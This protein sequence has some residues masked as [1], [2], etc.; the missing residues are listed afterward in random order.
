MK[1]F[2]SFIAVCKKEWIELKRY[3]FNTVVGLCMFLLMFMALFSGAKSI[4]QNNFSLMDSLEGFLIGYALW[5]LAM[6]AFADTA[7]AIIDE[8]RKGTLEQLYMTDVPFTWLLI[9]KNMI[10]TIIYS[11]IFVVIILIQTKVTGITLNLDFISVFITLFIG[12]FSL[13]GIG[14]ILAGLG[15]IFKK[16]QNLLGV[17]QF[18]LVGIMIVSP[19][20]LPFVRLL[21]FVEGRE[22][23]MDIMRNG[24]SLWD[25][26]IYNWLFLLA[27]SIF[28]LVVGIYGYKIA[29]MQVLKRGMLGQY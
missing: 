12:L 22:M 25:F 16:I 17:T 20:S 18:I 7:H 11:I 9:S 24:Y 28:Y 27:N 23:I 1:Y 19:T 13:Y 3:W 6:G 2:N 26:S 10:S 29:E 8:S 4:G 15:L 5:F 21:P 14:L